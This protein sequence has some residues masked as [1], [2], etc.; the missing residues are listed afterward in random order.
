MLDASSGLQLTNARPPRVIR[1]RSEVVEVSRDHQVALLRCVRDNK[2]IHGIVEAALC[3]KDASGTGEISVRSNESASAQ[4]LAKPRL[5]SAI[6]PDFGQDGC[7]D[8]RDHLFPSGQFEDP[9]ETTVITVSG[10]ERSGIED[11]RRE[12]KRRRARARSSSVIAPLSFSNAETASAMARIFSFCSA[13][14]FSQEDTETPSSLAACSTAAR[15]SSLSPTDLFVTVRMP[16]ILPR[17]YRREQR[18]LPVAAG[19]QDD[20]GV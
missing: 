1:K 8:D 7:Q 14:S 3:T 12:P 5:T 20:V 10:N 13:A 17:C 4:R 6:S 19:P 9:P 15:T 11:Q 18:T 2:S 16:P